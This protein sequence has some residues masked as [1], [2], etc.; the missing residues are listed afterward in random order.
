MVLTEFARDLD[1]A[2][3]YLNALSSKYIFKVDEI[4]QAEKTMGKFSKEDAD[5]NLNCHDMQ[6]MWYENHCGGAHYRLGNYRESL[7]QFKYIEKHL[8]EMKQ[9]C[10]DF[11][12][13]V[14]R[15]VTINHFLQMLKF[16]DELYE[17]KYP[18]R[19]CLNI[20]KSISKVQK[21]VKSGDIKIEDVRK[22]YEEYKETSPYK[23][24]K[25]DQDA[26]DDDVLD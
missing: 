15:K 8:E 14:F 6:T 2:D 1:Q 7:Q 12:H 13:Y 20:F 3:R 24:W 26:N 9:D 25:K 16:E 18:V 10:T 5:G 17:G 23:N 4:E 11:V 19:C 22:G 21:G